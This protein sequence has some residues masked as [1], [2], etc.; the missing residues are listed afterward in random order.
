VLTS[1]SSGRGCVVPISH[2]VSDAVENVGVGGIRTGV[3]PGT[4]AAGSNLH[5]DSS[6]SIRSGVVTGHALNVA[7]TVGA[8]R[9]SKD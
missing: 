8:F 1:G 7:E 4:L 5:M 3:I 6:A 2:G 9:G